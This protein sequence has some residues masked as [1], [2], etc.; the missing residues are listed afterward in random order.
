M[1]LHRLLPVALGIC[2]L[3]LMHP[4][5]ATETSTDLTKV[6]FHIDDAS[7]GRFALYLAEDHL[8]INPNM[9]ITIA[10]YAGG[11]DF[12]LK[13]AMDKKSELYAPDIKKLMDLGVQFRFCAATLRF[14]D[15]DK[16]KV[17]PG[18]EFV[19]SGTYE[20]IRLQAEEGYAYLK[21]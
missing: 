21:P 17:L 20:I 18:V 9:K 19:P 11:V 4:A 5:M 12:L 2:P 6:V 3:L 14:R 8:S 15:L 16:D 10:A 13:G 7:T 1:T